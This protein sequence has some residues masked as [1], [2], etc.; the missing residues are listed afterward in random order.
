MQQFREILSAPNQ[1]AASIALAHAA[2]R[3][4]RMLADGA[5]RTCVREREVCACHAR[6]FPRRE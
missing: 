3:R 1:N 2:A 6:D 4:K 5:R